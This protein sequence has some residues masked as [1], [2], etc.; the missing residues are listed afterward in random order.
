MR[1]LSLLKAKRYDEAEKIRAAYIPLE[2]QRDALGPIRVL[3]DAVTLAG[4]A[5]LGPLLPMISNLD[6]RERVAVEGP[7]KALLAHDR[8]LANEKAAA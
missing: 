7:A 4:I 6:A 5:D 3:H 8:Q 1:L 2:D